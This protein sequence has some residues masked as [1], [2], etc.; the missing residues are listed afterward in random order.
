VRHVT[1]EVLHAEAGAAGERVSPAA[2]YNTLH[3]F[4]EAGLLRQV[5]VDG[6]RS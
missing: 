6:M 1:A 2:V 3:Q 4:T 5:T